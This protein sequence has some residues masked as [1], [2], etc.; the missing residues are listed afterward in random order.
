[1]TSPARNM[2][3]WLTHQSYWL[4]ALVPALLP[5]GWALKELPGMDPLFAWL[6][7]PVLYIALPLL[8]RIIG[9]DTFNPS[10]HIRSSYTDTLVPV[11]ASISYLSVLIW[12]LMVLAANPGTFSPLA[13]VGWTVSLANMG[14]VVAINVSHELI[15]RRERWLQ[16]LGGVLLASVCYACFKLEH[17]RWHHV[18]VATPDDPS[19][20]PK[21]S[22]VYWR[23]PR[24]WLLNTLCGW[25][26][27]VGAAKK[28][29][30]VL[31]V[32]NHEMAA[33]YG[34]SAL[35][36]IAVGWSLGPL[37]LLVFLAHGVGAAL[38]LE[39]INY[40]EH[41]GLRRKNLANGRYEPPQIHHSW[42]SDY[43]LSNAMLLQLPRHADHHVHP[44]RPYAALQRQSEAPQLPFGYSTA[45]MV[46]LVPPLWHAVMDGRLPPKQAS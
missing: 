18:K 25:R 20:A 41:Y 27:S 42:D 29:D 32:I 26:L 3:S 33:W 39:V 6:S 12:A 11:V 44:S 24:A 38:L 43:W 8:D 36:A 23:A 4:A 40:V 15:H 10:E 34:L 5:L 30:R 28:S 35:L 19:S 16:N 13:L 45:V 22:N 7:L 46:A 17:P 31:P 2:P 14:G 1:M 21:G 9:R 37:P